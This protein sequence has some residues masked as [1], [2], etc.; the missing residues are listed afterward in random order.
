MGRHSSLFFAAVFVAK[1][2]CFFLTLTSVG[3]VVKL[4]FFVT[5]F[6]ANWA[7]VLVPGRCFRLVRPYSQTLYWSKNSIGVNTGTDC[8]SEKRGKV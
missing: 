2:K 7:R 4:L 3:N 8:C 1:E 6:A 5:D